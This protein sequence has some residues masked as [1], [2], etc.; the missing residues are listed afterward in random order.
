[1][2]HTINTMSDFI[3]LKGLKILLSIICYSSG[4]IMLLDKIAQNELLKNIHVDP[5]ASAILMR[6]IIVLFILKIVWYAIDK[7][8]EYKERI[9]NIKKNKQ[10]N[11]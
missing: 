2:S 3:V 11:E 9:S 10:A 6:L 1:M 8:L 7:W 5:T 4:G